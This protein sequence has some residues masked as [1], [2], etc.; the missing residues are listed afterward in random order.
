[1]DWAQYQRDQQAV[2]SGTPV[3]QLSA[4]SRQNL[5][6][7]NQV[8]ERFNTERQQYEALL[9]RQA[10]T[11]QEIAQL[12]ADAIKERDRAVLLGQIGSAGMGAIYTVDAAA[13]AAMASPNVAARA[14]GHAWNFGRNVGDKIVGIADNVSNISGGFGFGQGAGGSGAGAGSGAGS[15]N[16]GGNAQSGAR[17]ALDA[18]QTVHDTREVIRD[19]RGIPQ[20]FRDVSQG[21]ETPD[22]AQGTFGQVL[23]A[24]QTGVAIGD[25]INAIRSGDNRQAFERGGDA[26][27][28]AAQLFTNQGDRVEAGVNTMRSLE[29][30][31]N[32]TNRTDRVLH[33]TEAFGHALGGASGPAGNIGDAIVS[34]TD[35]VRQFREFNEI[36]QYGRSDPVGA[37]RQRSEQT[38]QDNIRM[39][40]FL[41][42]YQTN[43]SAPIQMP[44]LQ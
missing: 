14:L 35:A 8:V 18:A 44:R 38:Y 34:G 36:T 26:V 1:V 12:H 31:Y 20:N 4:A 30:A 21:R 2:Q 27:V 23:G 41:R 3:S 29:Q 24:A 25:T 9:Q 33:G 16:A 7:G 17:T 22:R 28:G 42:Q 6:R 40:E 32:A 10:Q 15:G 11:Q 19:V 37:A 5:E 39:F 43:P 13:H